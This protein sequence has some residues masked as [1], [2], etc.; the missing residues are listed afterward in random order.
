MSTIEVLLTAFPCRGDGGERCRPTHLQGARGRLPDQLPAE[1]VD[2]GFDRFVDAG[3]GRMF[4]IV[5][6]TICNAAALADRAA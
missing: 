2:Q 4:A 5:C 1:P 3:A 6:N